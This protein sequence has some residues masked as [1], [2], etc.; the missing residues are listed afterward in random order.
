MMGRGK[1]LPRLVF[2]RRGVD[3]VGLRLMAMVKVFKATQIL[4]FEWLTALKFCA[5]KQKLLTE[6]RKYIRHLW[7]AS[8]NWCLAYLNLKLNL[9]SHGRL[10]L[11]HR[12]EIWWCKSCDVVSAT[13]ASYKRKRTCGTGP[14]KTE[15][16]GRL[17]PLDIAEQTLCVRPFT[18]LADEGSHYQPCS[19]L[20]NYFQ[21]VVQWGIFAAD[22]RHWHAIITPL[23]KKAGRNQSSL[24]S[25]RPVSNLQFFSKVLEPI[26][27][28]QLINDNEF[29]LAS[30][31][32]VGAQT[33]LF[34]GNRWL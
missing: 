33:M 29:Q 24:L 14:F 5:N 12:Q 26:V 9:S 3:L 28:H 2:P 32:S 30:K 34:N 8:D 20:H 11:V 15:C 1:D 31:C 6:S 25:Y 19:V 10:P 23:L 27:N 7:R 18:D 16:R 13:I 21:H 17:Y 22:M 4:K